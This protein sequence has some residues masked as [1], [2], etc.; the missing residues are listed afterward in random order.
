MKLLARCLVLLALTPALA[1]SADRSWFV[2]FERVAVAPV[3]RSNTT[4]LIDA[5]TIDTDGFSEL[6]FSLGGEFKEGVPET[7]TVGAILIPDREPFLYLL[8]NEGKIVFPLEVR[9][10]VANLR[11]AI[12]VSPQQTAKIGFPRYRVFLY[13]ET[14]SGASVGLFVYRTR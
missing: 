10:D 14:S 8:R 12:F 5:G 11:D 3:A 9:A 13:N 1:Q 4:Q 6:V 7:G 2:A